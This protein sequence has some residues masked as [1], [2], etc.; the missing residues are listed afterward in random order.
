MFKVLCLIDLKK[1]PGTKI[2][3]DNL[4]KFNNFKLCKITKIIFGGKDKY[5]LFANPYKFTTLLLGLLF[6]RKFV[7]HLSDSITLFEKRRNSHFIKII[8]AKYIEIIYLIL[9]RKIVYVGYADYLLSTELHNKKSVYIPNGVNINTHCSDDNSIPYDMFCFF[10]GTMNYF[11]NIQAVKNIVGIAEQINNPNLKFLI[12]GRDL[13]NDIVNRIKFLDNIVYLGWVENPD[14]YFKKC[15]LFIAPIENGSGIQNKVL[16][17]LANG[18]QIITTN[19]VDD[20]FKIKPP[21][22]SVTEVRYFPKFIEEY[23]SGQ[24]KSIDSDLCKSYVEENHS[25]GARAYNISKYLIC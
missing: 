5:L 1:N 23:I 7:Y 21:F 15:A 19:S 17:A 2:I 16:E 13:P 14:I 18:C 9:F 11:P 12:A 8:I 4:L 3:V 25:W 6:G 24:I 22:L 20:A 10:I